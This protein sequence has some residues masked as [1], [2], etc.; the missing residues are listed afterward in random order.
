MADSEVMCK[1]ENLVDRNEG[2][3]VTVTKQCFIFVIDDVSTSINGLTL[4]EVK[5]GL[6]QG[7]NIVQN[8]CWYFTHQSWVM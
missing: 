2:N 3:L 8:D 5:M 6:P 1:H 4:L 7:Q